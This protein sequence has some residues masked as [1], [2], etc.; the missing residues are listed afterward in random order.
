[1]RF[2]GQLG[3]DENG[4]FLRQAFEQDGVDTSGI[5]E[6]PGY[7]TPTCWVAVDGRGDHAIIALPRDL[8]AYRS[9]DL[10]PQGLTGAQAIYIGPSHTDLAC[11]AAAAAKLNA[12]PVFYAPSTLSRLVSREELG[13]VLERTDV[14]FVSRTEATALADRPSPME[15]ASVLLEAGPTV[16]VET[17]GPEG[18][19]IATG[20]WTWHVPALS[21]TERRDTTGA[22]DAFA[23]GFVAAFLRGL[24]L[25]AAAAVG[26]AAAALKI[27]HLGART[28][29]P[30][31]EDALSRAELHKATERISA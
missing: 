9:L 5:V 12:I 10:D 11:R 1:V 29:L 18:A 30:N 21:V 23:A 2:V 31:W 3:D 17:V 28:G 13:A 15:A 24:D 26:C 6:I 19:F 8:A 7:E 20:E 22:G 14:L 25:P 4:D 16:I 27:P